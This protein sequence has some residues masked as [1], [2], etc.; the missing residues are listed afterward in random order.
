MTIQEARQLLP[1]NTDRYLVD[2]YRGWDALERG[3]YKNP[4]IDFDL[5]PS[6]PYLSISHRAEVL[7]RLVTAATG[8]DGETAG[9]AE[10]TRARLNA[11]INYL[12][13]LLGESIPFRSYIKRTLGVEPRIFTDEEIGKQLTLVKDQLWA[14]YHM[15]FWKTD[16]SRFQGRFMV[17]DTKK[18]PGQFERFQSK[19]V[20][21]LLE[22]IP[23]PLNEYKVNVRFASE[24]AYWKNWISGSLSE[25]EILLRINIHPRQVWYQGFS[26][27][28]VIHEYCGHAIQ[29]IS[30]HRRIERRELP[31][32]LGIL[33][34]HFPDQYLLEGLAESLVFV[35]PGRQELERE[36]LVLRD[37]H[38]YNLLIM[39][40]VHIIA[41]ERGTQEALQ[42]GLRNLPFTSEELIK[43][44]IRDR[45]QNPLF[46]CYQYVYGIAK[47]SFL[48]M[49]SRLGPKQS[50]NLLRTAYELPMTAAQVESTANDLAIRASEPVARHRM[51]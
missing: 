11:S 38:R 30:W 43:K 20:P 10:L 33:T 50:W 1:E 23:V 42:Y 14:E 32:F 18:L 26:E 47:E 2:L 34:V 44:E 40:N 24:D 37:L 35:L 22:R 39:N 6:R 25:H 27:M 4:I 19:W 36:S 28:L 48:A 3:K 13:A 51:A 41:N 31:E 49:F 15:Q 9:A 16:I 8:L 7:E 21:V 5:A 12:R 46:R 45:T 17:Y 29:M